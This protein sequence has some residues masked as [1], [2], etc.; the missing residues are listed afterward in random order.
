MCTW[1][2]PY[3]A[4]FCSRLPSS[5]CVILQCGRSTHLRHLVLMPTQRSSTSMESGHGPS[6]P[7][8]QC[9]LPSSTDSTSLSV[10]VRYGRDLTSSRMSIRQAYISPVLYV[11]I[12][13]RVLYLKDTNWKDCWVGGGCRYKVSLPPV[14]DIKYTRVQGQFP[15]LTTHNV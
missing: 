13:I 6:F 15:I 9:L 1:R 5:W 10:S 2:L 11:L 8:Y 14:T 3:P 4:M 12:R 7:T